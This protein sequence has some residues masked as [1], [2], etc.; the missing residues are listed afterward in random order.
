MPIVDIRDL[1]KSYPA[2]GKGGGRVSVVNGISFSIERGEVFG[3]LG[4]NGAGK[5]TTLEI[6]EALRDMD[7][8]TVEIDG[9]SVAADPMAVKQRIGVQLQESE[10]FDYLSLGELLSLFGALYKRHIAPDEILDLVQ[11]TGKRDARPKQ[12]SGGQRQ[13]FS[14]A[15]ALVNDPEVLFLDEPT[16][17]LDPQA[18][19]NLWDLVHRIHARGKTIVLT[20]HYMDEAEALCSR[21]AIMDAGKIIA[22]DTPQ[23]LIAQYAPTAREQ[24]LTGTLEDVFIALTGHEL[25]D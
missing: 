14:I 8:G 11:L 2:P 25:R 17:G 22:L 18:R 13:R 5:T 20:T 15:L 21:V 23:N 24:R 19:H 6:V 4:P 12:L 7:S 9:I 16:T 1:T 3:I 10:Y